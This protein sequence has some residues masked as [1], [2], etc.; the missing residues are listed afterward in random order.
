LDSGVTIKKSRLKPISTVMCR[1]DLHQCIAQYSPSENSKARTLELR[2]TKVKTT[3]VTEE[4]L[5]RKMAALAV[6][7]ELRHSNRMPLPDAPLVI[8]FEKLGCKLMGKRTR[9]CS[10][11]IRDTRFLSFFGVPALVMGKLWE[12]LMEHGG[13]W[14]KNTQ[15]K[16][17]LW[18]FHLMKVYSTEIVL[19]SNVDCPDEKVFRKW[20]WLFI[21]QLAYLE[22]HVVSRLAESN[23]SMYILD[24]CLTFADFTFT[25]YHRSF[26]RIGR[27]TTLATIV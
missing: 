19:A 8:E 7:A 11:D 6:T 16:H 18:A 20:A 5:L 24:R 1:S 26:G 17:L 21:E 2:E 9:G 10:E 14:P 13:P 23:L 15:K 4:E 22:F 27:P 12:L 3:M 25:T